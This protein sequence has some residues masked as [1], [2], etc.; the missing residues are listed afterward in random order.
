M[1]ETKRLEKD[2]RI[3]QLQRAINPFIIWGP[4]VDDHIHPPVEI[5]DERITIYALRFPDPGVYFA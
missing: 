2:K 4:G 3:Y 5:H 1:A